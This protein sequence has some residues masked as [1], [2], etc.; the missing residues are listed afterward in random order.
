MGKIFRYFLQGLLVIVPVAIT[1]FVVYKIVRWVALLF[2]RFE[3]VV[4][5]YA[6]PFIFLLIGLLLIVLVGWIASNYLARFVLRRIEDLIEQAP[7]IK[8]IYS[9]IKDFLSAF[10]GSKKRFNRPV[11]VTTNIQSNIRE[12][13][14]ITQDDLSELG[15]GKEVVA[16]Y[17]P[18]SYAISG[19]LIIVPVAQVQPVDVPAADAMK[20]IVSGGVT[21]ID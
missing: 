14:F 12:L 20:F 8:I 6:D 10:I 16:V 2:G 4:H 15:L 5:P 21:E 17:L 11:L 9:W 13:G 7:L 1:F 18:I 19:K 3:T